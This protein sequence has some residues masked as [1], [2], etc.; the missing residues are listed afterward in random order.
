MM[1]NNMAH[2]LRN[3]NQFHANIEFYF[4]LPYSQNSRHLNF[5][6]NSMADLIGCQ[7]IAGILIS[8]LA[9]GLESVLFEFGNKIDSLATGKKQAGSG[10]ISTD[11]IQLLLLGRCSEETEQF[12]TLNMGERGLQ[13]LSNSLHKNFGGLLKQSISSLSTIADRMVLIASRLMSMFK[14]DQ[15]IGD[16]SL[17]NDKNVNLANAIYRAAL[18][19]RLKIA[20]LHSVAQQDIGQ[21]SCFVKFLQ[22]EMN[23]LSAKQQRDSSMASHRI[24]MKDL[25]PLS[26]EEI[27][28]VISFIQ[29]NF[30]EDYE[31][32]KCQIRFQRIANFF[33]VKDYQ[34]LFFSFKHCYF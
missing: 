8:H 4:F 6:T 5:L 17:E 19:F 33:K 28:Q 18:Q 15:K 10:L 7:E 22:Y 2:I 11:F 32:G 24:D 12:F 1:N 25:V 16:I 20:Q 26:T 13:R 14:F 21:L 34:V 27:K 9:E 3:E 29:R 31:N 23:F 30:V